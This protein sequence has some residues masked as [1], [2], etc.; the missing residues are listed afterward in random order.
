MEKQ[1]GGLDGFPR[2]TGEACG[3]LKSQPC[4]D[5]NMLPGSLSRIP[6]DGQFDTISE[7]FRLSS[8]H[9]SS[10]FR[11]VVSCKVLV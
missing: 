1:G 7:E 9:D 5:L 4:S 10:E 2:Q 8:L 6:V 11:A 3:D